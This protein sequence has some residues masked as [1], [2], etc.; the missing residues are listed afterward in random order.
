MCAAC[1][2]SL[3][4]IDLINPAVLVKSTNYAVCSLFEPPVSSFPLCPSKYSS[5][6]LFLDI[7]SLCSSCNVIDQVLLPYETTGINIVLCNLIFH[8]YF[9]CF[10]V[11]DKRIKHSE[12]Q[13]MKHSPNLDFF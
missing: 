12:L 1:H 2:V 4:I 6:I 8:V 11:A 5:N 10:Y 13:G 3:I 9:V 7:L